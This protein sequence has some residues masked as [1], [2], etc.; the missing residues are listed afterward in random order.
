MAALTEMVGKA[1]E[2]DHVVFTFS[3]HGTQVP[4]RRRRRAG[5]SRRGVRLPRPEAGRRRLGPQDRDRRRRAARALR[6]GAPR[7]CC[8]RC[9]W[10]P[11]TAARDSRTST[12]S[13]RRCCSDDARGSCRHPR[14]R[15]RPRPRHPGGGAAHGG[16]QGAGRADQDRRRHEAGALRSLQAGPDRVRRDLRRPRE[17][18]VHLPVP[19]GPGGGLRSRRGASCRARSPRA[20]RAATSSSARRSRGRRSRRRCRSGS[21]SELPRAGPCQ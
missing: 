1:K 17:R 16:P 13:C 18:R 5:R 15:A 11:A 2:G 6:D 20:S 3:S 21:R 4:S 10:T 7:G 14:P 19:Q 12:T 9:S 8:S